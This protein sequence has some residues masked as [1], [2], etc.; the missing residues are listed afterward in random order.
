MPG[1]DKEKA[2]KGKKD[3]PSDK[4][5]PA[6]PVKKEGFLSG[7]WS[8]VKRN[9]K[10]IAVIAAVAVVSFFGGRSCSGNPGGNAGSDKDDLSKN[11]IETVVQT[12]PTDSLVTE[13]TPV[14]TLATPDYEWV[15]A[16]TKWNS[17]MSITEA[18]FNNMYNIIH[19]HS[20]DGALWDRMYNNANKNAERFGQPDAL[21]FMFKAMRTAAWTNALNG[22][23]CETHG[24]QWA[25]TYSGAFGNVVG[26]MIGVIKCDDNIDAETLAKA[27]IMLNAVDGN[28]RLNVFTLDQL[29]PGTS[30]Y[31]D[32]DAQGLII[33]KNRNVMVDINDDC[34]DSQVGF[35]MGGTIRQRRIVKPTPAPVVIEEKPD[36]IHRKPD[37][38]IINEPADTIR[39]KPAPVV[40]TEPADTI[41][42]KPAP[43]VIN[44]QPQGRVAVGSRANL[45]DRPG[46]EG[47]NHAAAV[48]DNGSDTGLTGGQRA[49]GRRMADELHKAGR[50]SDE[51]YAKMLDELKNTK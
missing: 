45:S 25:S 23:V 48:R 46:A 27:K 28:G 16:P 49:A 18:Q 29:V 12:N 4:D 17:G 43:V 50:I 42:N 20:P 44:E 15:D 9:A 22:R 33:G 40:I 14:D 10:K 37:P 36:T 6:K 35:R 3:V 34:A 26:P 38:V 39:H 13:I 51:V 19:K 8:K 24:A 47:V 21:S 2:G 5:A 7:L 1:D 30:R 11:K 31:N 41:R 32:H